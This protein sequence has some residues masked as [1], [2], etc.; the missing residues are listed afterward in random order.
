MPTKIILGN[1][2]CHRRKKVTQ[3][4]AQAVARIDVSGAFGEPLEKLEDFLDLWDRWRP[5]TY[6]DFIGSSENEPLLWPAGKATPD[7]TWD[8]ARPTMASMRSVDAESEAVV[9]R[10]Y[11]TGQRS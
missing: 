1:I 8:Y 4:G 9:I 6:G 10:E 7:D 3:P 11:V 5:Q 2:P